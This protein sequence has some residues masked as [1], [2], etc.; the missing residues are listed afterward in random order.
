MNA[1]L[2]AIIEDI[3][4]FSRVTWP[5][6]ALRPYQAEVAAHIAR[7]VAGGAGRQFAVVFARQSGKDELLAQLEAFLL[8]RYH[9]R[10]GSI[11]VV[12]PTY[13]PQAIIG[14][15]RLLDRLGALNLYV[16]AGIRPTADGH[17]IMLGRASCCFL[18]ANPTAQARG[19]TASLM[20]ACNESQEVHCGRWDAV[21]D[22]MGAAYHATQVFAGTVWTS[23]TLL[24]RQMAYLS[25]LERKD[26]IKRVFRV[27][28]E[29]VARWVPQYGEQVRARIA[30]FGRDHPFIRTE[31]FLEE[32]DAGG[33]LFDAAR[34]AR[35]RGS[36][37]RRRSATPGGLYALL[38]DV[39]GADEQWQDTQAW[40]AADETFA[41]LTPT[42][43]T[44]DATALTVVQVD[45][46]GLDDPLVMR[47]TYRVVDRYLW[48]G[49]PHPHLHAAITDLARNVWAAR[50]VVVDATG[51][52]AGLAGFLEQALPGRVV[53]FVFT[54]HSKSQLGWDFLG[55][56]DSGRYKEY[57]EDGEADT[58]LF[59]AQV[60]ACT[61]QVAT[62]PGKLL[63]WGVQHRATH[64]DLLV[65]AAL[66]AV[67]DRLD[68]RPRTARGR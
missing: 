40:P 12:N 47:P 67:L 63:R 4:A 38:V 16:R 42:H 55:L 33:R 14:K 53:P 52:G 30:Q 3:R 7:S 43:Y 45:L 23:T 19:E 32:L 37:P 36:H 65:S 57:A 56:I 6:R 68:W 22:P 60:E 51:V 18:S 61:S 11:V 59:W 5:H 66:C 31:Y 35:M 44:R 20:L 2:R 21:F 54:A 62:G 50:W 1:G 24:A 27:G 8:Y 41:P 13:R 26:G 25:E 9:L 48:V 46:S 15:R 10:G 64:D 34:R 17:T 28:W 58:G 49:V 39:A 29:E